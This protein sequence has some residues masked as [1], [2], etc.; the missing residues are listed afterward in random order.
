MND[1]RRGSKRSVTLLGSVHRVGVRKLPEALLRY[2]TKL[3]MMFKDEIYLKQRVYVEGPKPS[4]FL[5]DYL[6][7]PDP[8][9]KQ[10]KCCWIAC[11]TRY[12]HTS[13]KPHKSLFNPLNS[14]KK[15]GIS[16]NPRD[17]KLIPPLPPQKPLNNN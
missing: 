15:N 11:L 4:K 12:N 16:S 9:K 17:T 2:S 14:H 7:S 1:T 13:K 8:P 10:E 3:G 6:S 5:I